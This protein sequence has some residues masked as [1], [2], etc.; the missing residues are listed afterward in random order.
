V[1]GGSKRGGGEGGGAAALTDGHQGGAVLLALLHVLVQH[2]EQL[3]RALQKRRASACGGFSVRKVTSQRPSASMR[4][5]F[6]RHA[7]G[8]SACGG[9]AL[10]RA[11]VRTSELLERSGDGQASIG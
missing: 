5:I 8:M 3:D 6:C 7:G 10:L 2:C 4:H 1:I 9:G 11:P